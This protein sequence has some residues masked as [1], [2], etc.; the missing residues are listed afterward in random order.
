MDTTNREENTRFRPP[1][2]TVWNTE[3]PSMPEEMMPFEIAEFRRTI[4]CVS[5]RIFA[6][7][8]NVAVQTVQAWEQGGRKP[9]GT[10]LRLLRLAYKE[11]RILTEL[12]VDKRRCDCEKISKA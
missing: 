5:Q 3:M 4:L 10:S 7:M 1:R 6:K 8:L 11:P 2:R 9:S 12:L